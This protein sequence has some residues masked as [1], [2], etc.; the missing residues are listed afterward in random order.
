MPPKIILSQQNIIHFVDPSE[1]IFCQSDNCYTSLYLT[2]GERHVIVK[3]LT[4]FLLEL[5]SDSFIRVNQ[6]YL[7]NKNHIRRIDKKKKS[8]DLINNYSIPFTV[9]LKNLMLS[10]CSI[11]VQ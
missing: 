8:I 4:K 7:I 10:F 5:N 6:S 2:N 11:A 3:S 9:S 1:I